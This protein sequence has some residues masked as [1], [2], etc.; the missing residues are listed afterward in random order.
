MSSPD[1]SFFN[2][3]SPEELLK[4]RQEDLIEVVVDKGVGERDLISFLRGGNTGRFIVDTDWK[5]FISSR[6]HM[7]IE[8]D[9]GINVAFIWK[10]RFQL[11]LISHTVDFSTSFSGV[12]P[13]AKDAETEIKDKIKS[14]LRSKSLE[15]K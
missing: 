14:F 8:K 13:K 3:K 12:D 1:R 15:I 2:K 10:G 5:I 4:Q 9:N 7:Q 11:S 6:G